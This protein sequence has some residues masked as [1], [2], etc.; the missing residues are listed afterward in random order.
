MVLAFTR[1]DMHQ[2]VILKSHPKGCVLQTRINLNPVD[3]EVFE[4]EIDGYKSY[5]DLV[6]SFFKQ[7]LKN[8]TGVDNAAT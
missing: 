6:K 3:E 7:I 5:E 2:D 1:F 4:K 8:K